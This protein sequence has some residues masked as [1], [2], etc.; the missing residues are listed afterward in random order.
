[1]FNIIYAEFV[2]LKKSY[3]LVITLMGG[4]LMPAIQ[5]W[6]KVIDKEYYTGIP[7]EVRE[8]FLQGYIGNIEIMS[9]HFTYSIIFS[10]IA[11]YIVS[12]EFTDKTTNVLYSYPIDRIKILI[13]KF[14]VICILVLLV[15]IVQFISSYLGIYIV[16][17]E[18][19]LAEFIRTDIKI[20]IYSA[21]LQFILL[22]IPILIASITKN[23]I[24]PIVYGVL[25][26][27]AGMV[28]L[29]V[30]TKNS[31]EAQFCPLALPVLPFYHY[32]MGDPIDFIIVIGV[33]VITFGLFTFFCI[34]QCRNLDIS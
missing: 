5:F 1:M 33:G 9:F 20:N 31:I 12:R 17:K 32:N 29:L 24:F 14:I 21:L 18:L 4:L 23:I 19:P 25:G 8:S 2:K 3:I 26:A 27:L 7:K 22:P 28:L 10:L 34:Y 30:M 13:G 16:W 15:Y 11:G 6:G